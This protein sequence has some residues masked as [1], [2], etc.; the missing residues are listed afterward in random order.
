MAMH[1]VHVPRDEACARRGLRKTEFVCPCC[2]F[3]EV[4]YFPTRLRPSRHSVYCQW[5]PGTPTGTGVSMIAYWLE[6]FGSNPR[7]PLRFAH[8]GPVWDSVWVVTN[9]GA[10]ADSL[11]PDA[12]RRSPT[13]RSDT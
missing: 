8:E 12:S 10:S 4:R 2:G 1:A 3:T 11:A 9:P 7:N 13:P 5:C 6:G